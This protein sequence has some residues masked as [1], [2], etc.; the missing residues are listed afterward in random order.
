MKIFVRSLVLA[1]EGSSSNSTTQFNNF[2]IEWTNFSIFTCAV[3]RTIDLSLF[4]CIAPKY[5]QVDD[6]SCLV[7]TTIDF[8][9]NTCQSTSTSAM[10]NILNLKMT[11]ILSNSR[12]VLRE[13]YFKIQ[14]KIF[15]LLVL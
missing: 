9:L 10:V 2:T 5:M 4:N 13:K 11:R 3:P 15:Q 7:E 12:F 8:Q 1:K 6:L 14:R